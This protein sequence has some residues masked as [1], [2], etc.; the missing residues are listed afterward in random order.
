MEKVEEC[1][2]KTPT[3]VDLAFD[4]YLLREALLRN[5]IALGKTNDL[6]LLKLAVALDKRNYEAICKEENYTLPILDD[7]D[8]WWWDM[9]DYYIASHSI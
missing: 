2:L 8:F 6:M 4:V 1:C 5:S 9:V 3:R 7:V